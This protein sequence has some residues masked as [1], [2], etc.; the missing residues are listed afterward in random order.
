M[1]DRNDVERGRQII[2]TGKYAPERG[3]YPGTI[4]YWGVDVYEG[5]R[6]EWKDALAQEL[7]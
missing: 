7:S 2:A 4:A 5:S 1:T 6:Q 3:E